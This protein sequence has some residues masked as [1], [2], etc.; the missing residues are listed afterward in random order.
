MVPDTHKKTEQKACQLHNHGSLKL[1]G[2][3]ATAEPHPAGAGAVLL[4]NFSAAGKAFS[5]ASEHHQCDS[6]LA[7]PIISSPSSPP[8]SAYPI[9]KV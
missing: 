2:M 8:S 7:G 9:I 6:I 5:S 1:K 4:F 3:N